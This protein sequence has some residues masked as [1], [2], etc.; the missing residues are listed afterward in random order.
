MSHL[1]ASILRFQHR[2]RTYQDGTRSNFYNVLKDFPLQDTRIAYETKLTQMQ[3]QISDL[4][5]RLADREAGKLSQF[6]SGDSFSEARLTIA[7]A[8]GLE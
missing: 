2:L 7:G 8:Y 4:T 3:D 5:T 1:L 6:V